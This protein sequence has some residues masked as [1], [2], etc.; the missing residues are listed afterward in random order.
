MPLKQLPVKWLVVILILVPVNQVAGNYLFTIGVFNPVTGLTAGLVNPTLQANLVG[1]VVFGTIIFHFGKIGLANIGA[2]GNKIRTGLKW[3]LII[4]LATQLMVLTLTLATGQPVEVVS[5]PLK[6]TGNFIGQLMGNA[7]LEE[8]L[9]R[10][11]LLLQIYLLLRRNSAHGKSLVIALVISQLIFSLSHIPNRLLLKPQ[12]DLL[13]DLATLLLAGL[14][15]ALIYLRTTNFVFVVMV[16]TFI[17]TPF[18]IINTN[19][20]AAQIMATLALVVTVIW[21]RIVAD[22][23]NHNFIKYGAESS[24]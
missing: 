6:Y 23:E 12:V 19:L 8:L 1:L 3:G 17:N 4:W 22:E 5:T 9:Y 2:S 18:T 20:P 14:V 21:P 10:G 16:H 24:R 7:L 13:P 15:L 11:I